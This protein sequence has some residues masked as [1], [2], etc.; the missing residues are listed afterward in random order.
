MQTNPGGNMSIATMNVDI[1]ISK[2]IYD[3]AQIGDLVSKG[4]R[5][6]QTTNQRLQ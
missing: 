4:I 2:G 1:S 6:Q 3:P 5:A